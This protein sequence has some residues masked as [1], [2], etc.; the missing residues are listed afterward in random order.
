MKLKLICLALVAM[1]VAACSKEDGPYNLSVEESRRAQTHAE[2]FFN[3]DHPAGTN[4][5]GELVKKKGSFQVCRPQDSN[6]NGLVS[7]TG[8]LPTMNGG[9]AQHTRYCGYLSGTNAVMGCS[10]KDQV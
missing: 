5:A 3:S 1:S 7:C 9:F 4:P 6:S 8:M 10:D 2:A